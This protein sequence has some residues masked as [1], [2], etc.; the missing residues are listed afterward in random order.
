MPNIW[1]ENGI[2]AG[3]YRRHSVDADVR[4]FAGWKTM[5][6][7]F[8]T[9]R[10]EQEIYA[11]VGIFAFKMA[12]RITEVLN[13]KADM[14]V[15]DEESG[16]ILVRNFPIL[17]RWK[18]IDKIIICERCKT[19]NGKFETTCTSCGANLLYSGKR[20]Y[21]TE[22][23]DI[24]RLP[25]FIKIKEHF[26]EEMIQHLIKH[27][28]GHL[29]PS[30]YNEGEPY[31]RKWA[32]NLVKDYGTIVGLDSLY[33]HWFRSQRL[34]QLGNQYKFTREEL[35][36][37]SGIIKDET[38]DKYSKQIQSYTE[39]IGLDVTAEKFNQLMVQ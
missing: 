14:F 21:K 17:K 22:R 24:K 1:G 33:N 13:S 10:K 18:A 11:T 29:F 19:E 35:K 27:P 25:F 16:F 4:F 20:K 12:A 30:P 8:S 32:W 23:K 26:S 39:K 38:L 37:F 5:E 3:Q 34:M 7:L 28:N 31:S 6:E 2:Y 15:L 9:I 36:A